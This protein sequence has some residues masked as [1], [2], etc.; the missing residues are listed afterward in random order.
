MFYLEI[1]NIILIAVEVFLFF[2][3][4]DQVMLLRKKRKTQYIIFLIT[5]VVLSI[6]LIFL[7]PI[8]NDTISQL[9]TW[10][11]L[12][13]TILYLYEEKIWKKMVWFIVSIMILAIPEAIAIQIFQLLLNI[14][15]NE[16]TDNF[17]ISTIIIIL[18]R[19][20]SFFIIKLI[21]SFVENRLSINGAFSKEFIIMMALDLLI[22]FGTSILYKN[23]DEIAGNIDI[24]FFLI[25]TGI[26]IVLIVSLILVLKISKKSQE[27]I[28]NNKKMQIL[29]NELKLNV[30]I[31]ISESNLRAIRH[32]IS[33]IFGIIKGLIVTQSY[34]ELE[35]YLNGIVGDIQI[36][37]EIIFLEDKALTVLLNNKIQ[38]ARE[39]GVDFKSIISVC[40]IDNML[41][42]DLCSLMGNILDNAIEAAKEKDELKYVR[43]IMHSD[44]E[45]Y[46]ISCENSYKYEPI[47]RNGSFISRK[48]AYGK[49][50][51]QHG[52]GSQNISDIVKKYN[53]TIDIHYSNH[54]FQIKVIFRVLSENGNIL[55]ID[56]RGGYV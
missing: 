8:C 6:K 10:L 1:C 3:L 45:K 9:L 11:V 27:I 13:V 48:N 5:I 19:V 43:L 32:N 16:L 56:K 53:G 28:T 22:L 50:D 37:N 34:K 40:T 54:E 55:I 46:E 38:L 2:F 4:A 17:L 24:V 7:N 33:N 47:K 18:S 29:E 23:F 36:A 26:C 25:N 21:A 14:S 31:E 35:E 41:N 51:L 39:N 52:I 20:I 44:G 15:L 49:N 30:Q 42:S 12:I